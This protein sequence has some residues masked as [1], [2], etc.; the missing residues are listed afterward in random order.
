MENTICTVAEHVAEI[1]RITRRLGREVEDL[2]S[3]G[4][5]NRMCLPSGATAAAKRKTIVEQY[6]VL[7]IPLTPANTNRV[8]RAAEMLR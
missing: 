8:A 1:K 4:W 2:A 6:D 5:R 3:F 7:G